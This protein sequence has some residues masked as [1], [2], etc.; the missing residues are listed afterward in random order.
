MSLGVPEN[1]LGPSGCD[2]F[3]FDAPRK[4]LDNTNF[5][6]AIAGAI[7]GAYHVRAVAEQYGVPVILHTDHCATGIQPSFFQ[8]TFWSP[9]WEVT[10][11]AP[12]EVI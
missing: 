11:S 3:F 4:G 9:K 10:Y 5:H 2:Y 6:A 7:S 1:T 12:E 8:V